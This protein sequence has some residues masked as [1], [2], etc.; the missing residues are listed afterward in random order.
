MSEGKLRVNLTKKDGVVMVHNAETGDP[1]PFIKEI[2][3][4]AD[5]HNL[6][7]LAEITFCADIESMELDEV[8]VS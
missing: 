4:F 3:F 1:L 6:S 5:A 7:G 2:S 8:E